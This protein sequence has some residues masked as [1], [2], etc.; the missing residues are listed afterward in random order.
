MKLALNAIA[1]F[2][3]GFAALALLLFLPAGTFAYPHAWLMIGLL[4][5]PMLILGIV[6]F[7]K[8]P[9]L[10]KKRL[11]TKEKEKAQKGIVAL[12]ALAFLGGFVVAALD[13]RFSWSGVP[14]WL[15]LV[16]SAIFLVGYAMY[17]EVM[18]ENA[19]LSRTVRVEEGQKVIDTG[20]YSFVRHPMYFATLLLFLPMPI[21]LGSFYAL[22]PFLCYIP[23][24]AA[25]IISEEKLLKNELCGYKE[26]TK[27]VKY[28]LIPFV[29]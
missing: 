20:L 9:D 11:D 13:F 27:K 24:I 22:I 26:Y 19:Y 25:R 17:A 1:K 16:C 7:A 4:F 18:R 14:M 10:L 15:V 23:I 6:L 3:L 29:W 2:S 21:I 28:R 12:S 8:A 5:V